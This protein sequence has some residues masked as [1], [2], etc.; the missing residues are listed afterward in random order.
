MHP[1]T[2]S[3]EMETSHLYTRLLSLLVLLSSEDR[4]PW[5]ASRFHLALCSR[6]S[7]TASAATIVLAQRRSGAFLD[8][9]TARKLEREG[10]CAVLDALVD[11]PLPSS[12]QSTPLCS[13]L[14]CSSLTRAYLHVRRRP[15]AG[16][17]CACGTSEILGR[18]R[19]CWLLATA[20][21]STRRE[22]RGKRILESVPQG[23]KF[24][25]IGKAQK[26][27]QVLHPVTTR[28]AVSSVLVS[29]NEVTQLMQPKGTP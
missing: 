7:I 28:C 11:Y 26:T 3:L 2:A 5:L 12:V 23:L 8:H 17:S 25:H 18:G 20:R 6:G 24:F 15:Q 14:R 1:E 27:P 13:A 4:S 10:G 16:M 9:E 19:R 29:P 22:K 21:H